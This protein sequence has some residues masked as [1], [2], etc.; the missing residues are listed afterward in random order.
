MLIAFI[1]IVVLPSLVYSSIFSVLLWTLAFL[2]YLWLALR[3]FYHDRRFLLGIRTI[4]CSIAYGTIA[5]FAILATVLISA[6][7]EIKTGA[8]PAGSNTNIN[9]F[10]YDNNPRKCKID[11]LAK[12]NYVV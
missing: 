7:I 6:G 10:C 12:C 5:S 8:L 9:I 4:A 2:V 11:R 3:R 1:V